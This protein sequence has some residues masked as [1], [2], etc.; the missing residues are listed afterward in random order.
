MGQIR[1]SERGRRD[2]LGTGERHRRSPLGQMR[3]DENVQPIKLHQKARVP[4]PGEC[5]DRTVG[6]DERYVRPQ[7][8]KGPTVR[9]HLRVAIP[10][11]LELPFP[12]APL[13]GVKVAIRET[14][15]R[16]MR[17]GWIEVWI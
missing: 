12:E 9:R 11:L 3:I 8:G 10:P 17:L 2:P 6:L 1:E 4:N 7:D 16:V 14:L 15:R 13:L 5:V